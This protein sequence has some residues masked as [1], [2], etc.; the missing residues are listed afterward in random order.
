[1]VM[2]RSLR[3]RL[4]IWE[5][6]LET[7]NIASQSY[8]HHLEGIGGGIYRCE[9]CDDVHAGPGLWCGRVDWVWQMWD[10]L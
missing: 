5:A 9:L 7:V 8:L 4:Q 3:K 10:C 2:I 1:M 6:F